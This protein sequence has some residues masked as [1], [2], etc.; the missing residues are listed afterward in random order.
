[1]MV[2][3]IFAVTEIKTSAALPQECNP[4]ERIHWRVIEFL[5]GRALCF[6]AIPRN[7]ATQEGTK[8]RNGHRR[9][10]YTSITYTVSE[11]YLK[12]RHQENIQKKSASQRIPKRPSSGPDGAT[13][14]QQA[15]A[16]T[17]A[18]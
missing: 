6:T 18:K 10:K 7:G 13:R 1:M 3:V 16:E 14:Q 2:T 12:I 9:I 17:P 8:V 11:A 5:G 4:Q 15:I